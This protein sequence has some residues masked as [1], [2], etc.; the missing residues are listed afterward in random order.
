MMRA[1]MPAARHTV[2]NT[3]GLAIGRTIIYRLLTCDIAACGRRYER[4]GLD[5][6]GQSS[7]ERMAWPEFRR[8]DRIGVS[9]GSI[10]AP[11]VRSWRVAR[12]QLQEG[13]DAVRGLARRATGYRARLRALGIEPVVDCRPARST[14]T[15]R[16]AAG[17]AARPSRCAS[18]TS[19]MPS[20]QWPIELKQ[21]AD[22]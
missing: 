14:V 1:L 16:A 18:P 21:G 4:P 20:G 2:M 3:S 7:A 22:R 11:R 15:N 13:T 5:R 17:P 12:E 10:R 8:G 9:S 6:T 19:R